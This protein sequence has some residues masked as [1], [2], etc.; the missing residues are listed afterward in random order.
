MSLLHRY[1][2]SYSTFAYSGLELRKMNN[3]DVEVSFTIKNISDVDGA[4]VAQV[5]VHPLESRVERPVVELKGFT[6]TYLKA[7]EERRLSVKLDVRSLPAIRTNL[8]DRTAV[9]YLQHQA[10][11]FY[12]VASKAWVAEPGSFEIRIGTSSK[13]FVLAAP[14]RQDK[15]FAWVGT[16]DPWILV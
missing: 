10:F 9:L 12:D 5:Y 2:L 3:F 16:K 15:K 1:G 7:G 6:K 13:H 8:A 11:S 14:F 4:E